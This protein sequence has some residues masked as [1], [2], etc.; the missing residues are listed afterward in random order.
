MTLG[1]VRLAVSHF[2][3][4]TAAVGKKTSIAAI[5]AVRRVTMELKLRPCPF[6]GGT[7]LD[8]RYEN[9]VMCK[10]IECG[11]EINFGHWVGPGAKERVW[12]AWNRRAS[13]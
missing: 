2:A 8:T 6:C 13:E 11:G 12:E 5:I 3:G 9:S 4:V 7:D 10:N 1:F